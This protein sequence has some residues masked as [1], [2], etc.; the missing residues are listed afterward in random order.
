MRDLPCLLCS[1]RGKPGKTI[2]TVVAGGQFTDFTGLKVGVPLE[3][4]FLC[5]FGWRKINAGCRAFILQ[6]SPK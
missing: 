5:R 4:A 6:E 3:S 2:E 1:W